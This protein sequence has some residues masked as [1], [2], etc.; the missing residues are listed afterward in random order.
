LIVGAQTE[1]DLPILLSASEHVES[2]SGVV[3]IRRKPQQAVGGD[4]C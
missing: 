4:G 3:S 1:T 2:K